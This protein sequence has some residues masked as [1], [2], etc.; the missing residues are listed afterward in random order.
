MKPVNSCGPKPAHRVGPAAKMARPAHAGCARRT[1]DGCSHEH[2]GHM[3]PRRE[4]VARWATGDEVDGTSNRRSRG[5]HRAR[6]ERLGAD[7]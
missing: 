4:A 1:H 6:G 5:G 7:K 3:V 2:D